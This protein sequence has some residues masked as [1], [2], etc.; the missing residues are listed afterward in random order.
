MKENQCSAHY[1]VN[2]YKGIDFMKHIIIFCFCL[3]F[4]DLITKAQTTTKTD[5]ARN[6]FENLS[7]SQG[8]SIIE[9]NNAYD[10]IK[11]TPYLSDFWSTGSIIM[12]SNIAFDGIEMKYDMLEDN[13]LVKDK[14][15]K[16]ILPLY[17]SIKSFY[18]TGSDGIEHNFL[19]LAPSYGKSLTKYIGFYELLYDGEIM[20]LVKRKKHLKHVESKGAYS[21]N[22]SYDEF[23]GMPLEYLLIDNKLKVIEFKR[24]KKSILS[25]LGDDE[26]LKNYI[27]TNKLN[28]KDEGDI[29]QIITYYDSLQ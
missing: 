5:A 4:V 12:L 14:T 7:R 28:L 9:F 19:N 21:S 6:S 10:G 20:L 13:V 18:Y 29:I 16:H 11:G 23:I 22:R 2:Y 15:G 8:G 17:G 3:F 24:G 27:K 25:S 1:V 26:N